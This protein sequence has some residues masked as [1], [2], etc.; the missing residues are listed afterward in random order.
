MTPQMMIDKF[1]KT[2]LVNST[3][4]QHGLPAIGAAD[5]GSRVRFAEGHER[6]IIL[7]K[8][9]N[10]TVKKGSFIKGQKLRP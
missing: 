8:V 9:L 1:M 7:Q 10:M 5:V 3:S 2:F 4:S 6:K